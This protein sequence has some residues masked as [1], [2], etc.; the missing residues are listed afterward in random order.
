MSK[1]PGL[2]IRYKFVDKVPA[3]SQTQSNATAAGSWS[4]PLWPGEKP[5]LWKILEEAKQLASTGH[6]EEALQRYLWHFNH[7]QEYG[8]WNWQNAVRVTSA[9]SEWEELGRRYPKARQALIEIRDNKT[10]E[11]VE[12]RGYA[13]LFQD[14]QAINRELQDDDATYALFKTIRDSDPKLVEQMLLLSADCWWPGASIN[15]AST[16]WAMRR[17]G[18]IPSGNPL[19]WSGQD[20]PRRP[21][22]RPQT[23]QAP[24]NGVTGR[25][26]GPAPRPGRQRRG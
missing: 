25:P 5:D 17:G 24:T 18:S 13:E 14:V 26:P 1:P 9:L 20:I 10:R 2:K 16:T 7:A 15:G 19:K 23:P 8:D 6:Y 11:I 22:L 12:G 21:I 4:P 3:T